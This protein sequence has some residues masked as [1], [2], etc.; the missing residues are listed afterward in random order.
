MGNHPDDTDREE[1]HRICNVCKA[2]FNIPPQDCAEMMS[3][4]ASV[5]PEEIMPGMVLVTKSTAA[6]SSSRNSQLNLV[7][8]AYI[9]MKAA[10]FREAVYVI[11][12]IRPDGA[13]SGS[14]AVLGVNLSR[15]LDT[16]DVSMLEGAPDDR[17]LRAYERRGVEVRWMNGGPCKPRVVTAL[18][19]VRHLPRSRRMEACSQD[20]VFELVSGDDGV[21]YGFLPAILALAADEAGLSIPSDSAGDVKTTVLAW[22][23]F[24]QW[25]RTQLLG[26]IAR[27]SWGFCYARAVDLDSAID[28]VGPRASTSLWQLMRNSEI[29][30]SR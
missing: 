23:G 28:A 6:E 21:L 24:A 9:E 3:D 29:C 22:A 13:N 26:E 10:H 18:V 5:R 14:D 12:E 7:I 1:R 8:R 19:R 27:G 2:T 20:G 11:T 25:S 16:P 17:E 15:T 30:P 4:L